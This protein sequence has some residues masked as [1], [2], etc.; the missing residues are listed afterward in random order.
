MLKNKVEFKQ[1]VGATLAVTDIADSPTTE[2]THFA[3]RVCVL[4]T[5]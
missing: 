4:G 3:S 2:N 1:K 5:M